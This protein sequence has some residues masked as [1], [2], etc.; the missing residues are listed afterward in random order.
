LFGAL[1]IAGAV[2]LVATNKVDV[3]EINIFAGVLVLQS[4]PFLS[5]A[6][7]AAIEGTRFNEHA[8]WT[9]LVTRAVE[10]LPRRAAA[11]AAPAPIEKPADTVPQQ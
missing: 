4:L 11:I 3:R 2:V 5:A 1:L 7:L 10:V 6:L 8:Y 9:S